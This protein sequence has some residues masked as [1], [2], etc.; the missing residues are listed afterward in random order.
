MS[1]TLETTLKDCQDNLDYRVVAG[2]LESPTYRLTVLR[3]LLL[4]KIEATI[5]PP[6]YTRQKVSVATEGD[7]RVIEG[8][9][10]QFRFTLDRAVQTAQLR[11]FATAPRDGKSPVEGQALSPSM[12]LP[13]LP[14][15]IQENVL[16]GSLPKVSKPVEY[17]LQA[18]AA[19]GMPLEPRRFRIQVQFDQKPTIS[20]VKPKGEIEVTPTTEVMMRVQA[21]DDFGLS[22][23]G[24]VYQIGNGPKKTLR[25]EKDPKE[26]VTLTTLATLYLEDYRLTQQ[27]SITYYAFAEDNYPAGPHR[28]T[29]ELQFIDIRPYKLEY[30]LSNGGGACCGCSGTLEELIR[31]QRAILQRTFTQCEESSPDKQA[32]ERICQGRARTG[33]GHDGIRGQAGRAGGPGPMPGKRR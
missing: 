9:G 4:Q 6:A 17:E 23:V 31:R 33:H 24:I 18:E 20:F 15:D 11:L 8:S 21:G 12:P 30:Q 29:T 14:L 5:E 13:P 28:V 32:V 25:L 7:F 22:K 27:D 16:T 26:P 10:V 2:R 1:G 19:D 3:P